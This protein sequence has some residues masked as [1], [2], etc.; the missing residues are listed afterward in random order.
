ML[1]LGGGVQIVGFVAPGHG[2]RSVAPAIARVDPSAVVIGL[3]AAF[4]AP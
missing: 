3:A 4:S 1:R 2:L